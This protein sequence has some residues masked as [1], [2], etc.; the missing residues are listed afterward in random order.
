MEKE[1]SQTT[2]DG[3]LHSLIF[4]ASRCSAVV[5]ED[6]PISQLDPPHLLPKSLF[7]TSS[8]NQS[9]SN[10]VQFAVAL[11]LCF[12]PSLVHLPSYIDNDLSNRRNHQ[13]RNGTNSQC[14]FPVMGMKLQD[15]AHS[16]FEVISVRFPHPVSL[17]P[18]L[19]GCHSPSK[20]T[21]IQ[22]Q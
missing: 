13:P 10:L 21:L 9:I 5:Q 17:F 8:R 19:S 6:R 20:D 22:V 7:S 11:F 3:R 2:G 14:F 4:I 15:N 1:L 12:Q 18:I 16:S